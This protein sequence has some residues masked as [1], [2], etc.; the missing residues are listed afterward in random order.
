M[1]GQLPQRKIAHR[2][3]LGFGL[4]LVLELGSGAIFP[5]PQP[6]L[7][8][9]VFKFCKV[10]QE[11]WRTALVTGFTNEI[12]ENFQASLNNNVFSFDIR[13]FPEIDRVKIFLS[14][15]HADKF[16][17]YENIFFVSKNIQKQKN[18]HSKFLRTNLHFYSLSNK[19]PFVFQQRKVL[20]EKFFKCKLHLKKSVKLINIFFAAAR[21]RIFFVIRI[22]GSKGIFFGLIHVSFKTTSDTWVTIH[23]KKLLFS[24]I[25]YHF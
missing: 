15:T 12:F 14:P 22:S 19:G 9:Y 6:H 11:C 2:L 23:M 21:M 10:E 16:N 5:E 17:V 13:L 3:G 8:K 4:G 20:L 7:R 24:S 1:S 18:F 25:I